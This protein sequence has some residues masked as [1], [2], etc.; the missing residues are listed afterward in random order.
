MTDNIPEN[1]DE[2]LD[3]FL[4]EIRKLDQ[5]TRHRVHAP[6]CLRRL[7]ERESEFI[8]TQHE[9][10]YWHEITF[11]AFHCAQINLQAQN[12]ESAINYLRE[13]L[14]AAIQY[15]DDWWTDYV[16]ATFHYLKNNPEGV[17]NA[18]KRGNADKENLQ[19]M[20]NMLKGLRA[21]G[22]P[23]YTQDYDNRPDSK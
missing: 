14:E 5:S 17:E 15:G 19:I 10:R 6:E 13:S 9:N 20:K 7:K 21:R 16:E 12:T 23:D 11:E 1:R 22:F 18:I 2:E 8:G 4:K 3:A